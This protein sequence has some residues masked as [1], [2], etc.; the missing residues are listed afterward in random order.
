MRRSSSDLI[1]GQAHV[2]FTFETVLEICR[3]SI[4]GGYKE[5]SVG[6]EVEGL[7]AFQNV[8]YVSRFAG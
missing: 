1:R 2:A 7:Q 6:F 8:K 4:A 5:N 3:L